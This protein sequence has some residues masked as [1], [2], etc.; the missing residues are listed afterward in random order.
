MKPALHVGVPLTILAL[1]TAAAAEAPRDD[2]SIKLP[3]WHTFGSWRQAQGLAQETLYVIVQSRDGYLWIGTKGGLVRFDGV[4]FTTFDDR[5]GRKLRDSEVWSI[6]E[7]QDGSL[8]AG[9]YGGGVSRYKDGTFTVYTKQQGLVGDYVSI[10]CAAP[11]GAVWFGTD[12]GLSRFKDERFTSF[13]TKE[14]LPSNV[15][16]GLYAEADGTVWIGANNGG[17]SR[18]KDGRIDTVSYEGASLKSEVR[19][20]WRAPDQAL[21]IG[22]YDG[23]ARLKDG[24]LI[25]YTTEQGLSSNR[26]RQLTSDAEGAL[27]IVTDRGLDRMASGDAGPHIETVVAA[28]DVAAFC[29]DHEGSLWVGSFIEGLFRLRRGLFTTYT[30]EDGMADYYVSAVMQDH[31]GRMWLGT[32]SG[33]NRFDASGMHTYGDDSGMP[34]ATIFSLLE[35]RDHRL[36]IGSNQ[37]LYRSEDSLDCAGPKCRERF[38]MVD[39]SGQPRA[40]V[41]FVF[42]AQDGALWVGLDQNGVVRM[43]DGQ[44]TAYSTAEGLA[45]TS[46]RGIAQDRAGDLW[47]GTRGGGLARF[48]DGRFSMLTVKDGLA[49]DGVQAVFIDRDDVLWIATR[50]GLSRYENGQIRSYTVNDG[51]L[52]SYVYSI[53][54]DDHGYLWMGSGK[55]VFRARKKDF[56]D[57]TAHRIAA[58]ESNGYGLE[59]G[60]RCTLPVAGSHPALWRS[61]DGLMWFGTSSG[62]SVVDPTRITSNRLAPPVHIEEVAIDE[63]TYDVRQ[64]I[65]VGPGHGNVHFRYAGLSYV[66]PEKMRFKYRLEGYDPDWIDAGTRRTAYY[67]NIPPGGYHFQVMA[68]NNDGVWNEKG[69]TVQVSLAPHFYQTYWFGGLCVAGI[70]LMGAGTQRLRVKRLQQREHELSAR[71]AEALAQVK[72]LR[73][74][75]PICA[76]CKKIRD[77]KGYWNQMEVYI[78]EH[79]DADFSHSVCP[80]C[81]AKLYPEYAATRRPE[82]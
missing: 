11:D 29:I 52:A 6:A 43:K 32:R 14:G 33:L 13:T 49:G 65:Q 69:A 50:Q 3:G 77:D 66:A 61:R 51:L 58:I 78:H 48:H 47:M 56:D 1:C 42:E 31:R 4:S 20:F 63:K 79:S 39:I 44:V 16:R 72:S 34:K 68:S 36:W 27:W 80:D 55:G 53:A 81:M 22:G 5:D 12:R 70:G 10:V 40:Y 7:A 62:V 57:F 17:L 8:W 59:H 9:T 75:L 45:N 54:E 38:R 28:V 46:M 60:M 37:G 19:W 35:D 74:L 41:R 23:L 26:V 21:W 82:S 71:V 25:L 30:P 73:G 18:Y 2:P 64:P 24:K 67:T 15:V 76:S